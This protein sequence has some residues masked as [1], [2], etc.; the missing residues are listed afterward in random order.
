MQTA[1]RPQDAYIQSQVCLPVT[2]CL[3]QREMNEGT[4]STQR[5]LQPLKILFDQLGRPWTVQLLLLLGNSGNTRYHAIREKLKEGE[6]KAI[7][8]ATLSKRLSSL[9]DL[10]LIERHVIAE[11]PPQVEY[12]LSNAGTETH[13]HICTMMKWAQQRCHSG[14]LMPGTSS[15]CS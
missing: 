14:S 9:T 8:D 12:A 5:C 4:D 10:G 6:G 13:R 7:S 11:T 3:E 1:P 15:E 2:M